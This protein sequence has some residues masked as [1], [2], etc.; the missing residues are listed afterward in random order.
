MVRRYN[1]SVPDLM[2]DWLDEQPHL[3]PSG[4]LQTAVREQM[5]KE[6]DWPTWEELVRAVVDAGEPISVDELADRTGHHRHLV[7]EKMVD[8]AEKRLYEGQDLGAVEEEHT[9][10]EFIYRVEADPADAIEYASRFDTVIDGRGPLSLIEPMEPPEDE[11][12]LNK[13]NDEQ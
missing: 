8:L 11:A 10:G 5:K 2:G 9:D 1:V 4:L 7:L 13:E 6:G 3:N 12:D